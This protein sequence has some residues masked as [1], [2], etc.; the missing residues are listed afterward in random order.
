[1]DEKLKVDSLTKI[2]EVFGNLNYEEQVDLFKTVQR[3]LADNRN[4]RAE[5]LFAES[6]KMKENALAVNEGTSIIEGTN[7]LPSPTKSY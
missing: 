6:A 1:M 7:T 4:R 5:E 3:E 2:L